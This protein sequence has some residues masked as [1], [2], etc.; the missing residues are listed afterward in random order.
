MADYLDFFFQKN[1]QNWAEG[2]KNQKNKY[3]KTGSKLINEI[4]D[5][6]WHEIFPEK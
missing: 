4:K 6:F 2:K 1:I 5:H 3:L